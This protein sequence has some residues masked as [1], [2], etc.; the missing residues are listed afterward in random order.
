MQGTI[1]Q[2]DALQ[3]MTE[4]VDSNTLS[5]SASRRQRNAQ[6]RANDI[7]FATEIG[8]SLLVEV[9]RLQA[10]L[11]ERDTQ[12][13]ASKAERD[14][15]ERSME[16]LAGGLKSVEDSLEKYREENWNLEV[17]NQEVK[18]QLGDISSN[19]SKSESERAKLAKELS[20]TRDAL[21]AQK[22]DNERLVSQFDALKSKHETDM[23]N[24]RRTT[25]GLQREKSDMQAALEAAK[26]ELAL[27]ARG[28]RRSVSATSNNTLSTSDAHHTPSG[29]ANNLAEEDEDDDEDIFGTNRR[30]ALASRRKTNDGMLDSP[31]PFYSDADNSLGVDASPSV[32]N[33][34]EAEKLR[35]NLAHAQK[36]LSSLRAALAREKEAKMSLKRKLGSGRLLDENGNDV[37]LDDDEDDEDIDLG[38]GYDDEVDENRPEQRRRTITA[39]SARGRR[40]GGRG[41]GGIVTSRRGGVSAQLPRGLMPSRLTSE[42]ASTDEDSADG[43]IIE[44][45]L[46]AD[47]SM[48]SEQEELASLPG[49][50]STHEG[51]Q[52][53]LRGSKASFASIDPAFADFMPTSRSSGMEAVPAVR[54]T[55]RDNRPSSMMFASDFNLL[56][57]I[58]KQEEE[59]AQLKAIPVPEPV[60]TKEMGIMTDEV[61]IPHTEVRH[62]SIQTEEVPVK[63][64]KHFASQTTA[65]PVTKIAVQEFGVQTD[66]PIIAAIST[67]DKSIMTIAEEPKR[68]SD[69]EV[70]TE[71]LPSDSVSSQTDPEEQVP[72]PS[73]FSRSD[74][75]CVRFY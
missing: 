17:Q 15:M 26:N 30:G 5:P 4:D 74:R 25:A 47:S 55:T 13:A 63:Q 53:V 75:H 33:I 3:G 16:S 43:S 68:V 36:M 12:L 27:R 21:D 29:L 39:T 46:P 71:V 1:S 23:A 31:S 54:G 28:I 8:Q 73:E 62:I 42:V 32:R 20:S 7:E 37:E 65:E 40:G 2:N 49:D 44:R 56:E 9:R 51:S 52:N 24:M 34:S 72:V 18:V 45:H 69:A 50:E 58:K 11:T 66:A 60:E 57:Q 6:H 48:T 19:L 10:L 70:M 38:S 59:I 22:M 41:R 35:G 67:A 14:A 64:F 61:I